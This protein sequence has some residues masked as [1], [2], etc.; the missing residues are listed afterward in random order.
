MPYVP[1]P[2]ER[3]I[4]FVLHCSGKGMRILWET[5]EYKFLRMMNSYHWVSI[6]I[7]CSMS[8]SFMTFKLLYHNLTIFRIVLIYNHQKSRGNL[9]MNAQCKQHLCLP[10]SSF[11]DYLLVAAFQQPVT[12]KDQQVT[13]IILLSPGKFLYTMSPTRPRWVTEVCRS[14]YIII[15]INLLLYYIW[16]FLITCSSSSP[17]KY[18]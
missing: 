3:R 17:C 12:I 5:K 13:S 14:M 15:F 2:C 18:K 6:S 16:H 10:F 11:R 8:G 1:L 9:V 7:C 4:E